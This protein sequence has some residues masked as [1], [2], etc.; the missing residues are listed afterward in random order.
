MKKISNR[1]IGAYCHSLSIIL[2]G[3]VTVEE[4][5]LAMCEIKDE[6]IG[7]IPS[8]IKDH[9][10]YSL[11]DALE[12]SGCFPEY[13]VRM[14]DAGESSGKLEEVLEGLSGYFENIY[15]AE[16]KLKSAVLYPAVAMMILSLL[17]LLMA[18]KVLPLFSQV[19]S[20]LSGEIT[21]NFYISFA[22]AAAWVIFV[23]SAVIT[24][25]I[26]AFG[27]MWRCER[28]KGRAKKIL[29]KL[30][31]FSSCTAEMD[32]AKF[33]SVYSIYVSG[34][35][36]AGE[37]F[38]KAMESVEDK[39]LTEKLVACREK[40]ERG[41]GFSRAVYE[42]GLF[43]PVYSRVLLSSDTAGRE[44]E[45]LEYISSRQWEL[46]DEKL[47]TAAKAVEPVLSA[48]ITI[49]V[50]ILLVSVMLP[51]IGIMNSIG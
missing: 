48:A 35:A 2:S 8:I 47:N 4:A 50:G 22:S 46:A 12:K 33:T 20:S 37:A 3:G 23:L 21:G 11:K 26:G 44:A 31:F 38:S 39:R 28:L 1:E 5:V 13:M 15:N 18:V 43:I 24:L 36:D 29:R 14:V 45:G 32:L 42:A 16:G 10:E 34:A 41:V 51:L 17:L 25:F 9:F 49:S 6:A 40:M 30:P 27:F 7:G 19:Y